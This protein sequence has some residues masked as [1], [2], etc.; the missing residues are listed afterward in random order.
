M[1]LCGLWAAGLWAVFLFI[2]LIIAS[3]SLLKRQSTQAKI[4]RAG[5]VHQERIEG[6]IKLIHEAKQETYYKWQLAQRL[7][8][9]TLDAL[10]HDDHPAGHRFLAG[11]APHRHSACHRR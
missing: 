10:A 11:D 3:G 1:L 4:R 7:Q 2:I 8:E 9:L 5:P 6:W